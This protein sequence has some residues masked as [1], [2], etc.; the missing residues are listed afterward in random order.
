MYF[1]TSDLLQ[2]TVCI[3]NRGNAPATGTGV[4]SITVDGKTFR[5]EHQTVT[6][7]GELVL[8]G[9]FDKTL[10]AG[11]HTIT[12]KV[13]A[14]DKFA[15]KDESNN[16]YTAECEIKPY[17]PNRPNIPVVPPSDNAPKFTGAVTEKYSKYNMTLKWDKAVSANK[18]SKV[19]Y[20]IQ[21][22]NNEVFVTKKNSYTVK[23]LTLGKHFYSIRAVD[24]L[25]N[26]SAWSEMKSFTV[27]DL[28]PPTVKISAASVNKNTLKLTWTGADAKGAIQSY[29]ITVNNEKYTVPA[30]QNSFELQLNKSHIGKNTVTVTAFDGVQYSKT[31]TKKVTVKDFIAPEVV[32]G[33]S[34]QV[35][36]PAKYTVTLSWNPAVDNSGKI[37]SY[38]IKLSNGKVYTSKKN[39]LVIKK[40]E[41]GDYTFS[42]RAVDAAKNHCETWSEEGKFT[43]NDVTAPAKV[44]VKATVT[45][46][47]AVISWKAP[48][49]TDI[50]A[51][52]IKYANN[53]GMNNAT[54]INLTSSDLSHELTGLA[55]GKWYVT[56]VAVDA[57]GNKIE[58]PKA[59]TVNI[60]TDLPELSAVDLLIDDP[61]LPVLTLA[62][63][64]DAA[65][66]DSLS[67]N[68]DTPSL[69]ISSMISNY[70]ESAM[71]ATD[72]TLFNDEK[73]AL[74]QLAAI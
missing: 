69:D 37:K 65:L 9:T 33:V 72:L 19:Q 4:V 53:S 3:G 24:S 21:F 67:L 30:E 38:E 48:K 5:A 25:G 34:A 52:E 31:A 68:D 39:E 50:V 28:T 61:E 70:T 41:V 49:A 22:D 56:V 15:E 47:N 26:T 73:N 71:T 60:K 18:S 44:S 2:Y 63:E 74:N 23:N 43:V 12:V 35:T 36:N 66:S 27:E 17:E 1:D 13:D 7:A 55:K 51:Y 40:M 16:V 59:K 64:D 62:S 8:T 29:E 58:K 32:T 6:V 42:V 46:N 20:Y 45:G 57:S 14:D 54:T 10:S 11:K